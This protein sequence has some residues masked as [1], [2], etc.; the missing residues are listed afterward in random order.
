[1]S[2]EW[3]GL[4]LEEIKAGG[5]AVVI[6]GLGLLLVYLTLAGA[7][8]EPRRCRSSSCCRCRSAILGALVAQWSRGLIND[9]Y[10]QIGLVMLIGLSAKNGILIVE[11]AEQLRERGLS[12]R[13]RGG[14]G[15]AHPA[16]ADPDD[17]ARVHPRRR[18]R[19]CSPPAPAAR[20]ATRSARRS[21]AA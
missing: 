12:H 21:P 20:R 9:V 3:S 11:F 13:R 1:M 16:A 17:V 5:Q 7:V 4:S 14:R 18:C 6:F 19:W 2:F 10:C 15:G 8:R